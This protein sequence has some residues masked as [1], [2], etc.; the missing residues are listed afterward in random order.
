IVRAWSVWAPWE[1]FSLATS[2]PARISRSIISSVWLDGPSVQTIFARLGIPASIDLLC[3]SSTQRLSC[4][5][6][7]FHHRIQILDPLLQ[8]GDRQSLVVGM[9]APDLFFA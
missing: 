4:F 6:K 2:M 3:V 9:H 7:L 1:K 5:Y 8:C